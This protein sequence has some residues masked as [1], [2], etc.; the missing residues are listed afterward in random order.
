VT[1]WAVSGVSEPSKVF[2][3]RDFYSSGYVFTPVILH[4]AAD[5]CFPLLTKNAPP[6]RG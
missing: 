1:P 6:K 4:L 5:G 3:E 2:A